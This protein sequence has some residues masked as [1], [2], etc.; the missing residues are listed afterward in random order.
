MVTFPPSPSPKLPRTRRA[1]SSPR[2]RAASSVPQPRTRPDPP[3][4][5]RNR[6][7]L[8]PSSPAAAG[9]PRREV[10]RGSGAWVLPG[11]R[12]RQRGPRQGGHSRAGVAVRPAG[13]S[14]P[15]G[16]A[17]AQGRQTQIKRRAPGPLRP[18]PQG[19]L[20]SVTR[21]ARA[22]SGFHW[23]P[24]RPPGSAHRPRPPRPFPG[25][26]GRGTGAPTWLRGRTRDAPHQR[27]VTPVAAACFP[28]LPQRS[29]VGR[30]GTGTT[31]RKS[32][33]ALCGAARGWR[34]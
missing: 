10:R 32:E 5:S 18:Q 25:A 9:G 6:H 8:S 21:T 2:L 11:A 15:E 27:V 4:R 23:W 31:F 30:E 19:P 1:S 12:A 14:A 17:G 24:R 34:V 20:R 28:L 33:T 22:R 3:G 7:L 29:I 26:L 16:S 13:G